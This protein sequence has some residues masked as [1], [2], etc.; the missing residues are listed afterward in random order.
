M[1]EL[2][3]G[4]HYEKICVSKTQEIFN[5]AGE[6]EGGD[7]LKG[8]VDQIVKSFICKTKKLGSSLNN[9]QEIK[10]FWFLK[11]EE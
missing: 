4:R 7:D 8:R 2:T 5:K 6:G 1:R 3:Q 11:L 10:A 9:Q